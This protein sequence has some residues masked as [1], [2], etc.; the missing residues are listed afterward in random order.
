MKNKIGEICRVICIVGPIT[1]IAFIVDADL[2]VR[3]IMSLVFLGLFLLLD[4][5]VKKL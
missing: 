1:A 5:G 2:G 3:I 4:K